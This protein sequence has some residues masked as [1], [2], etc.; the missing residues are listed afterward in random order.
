M[1]HSSKRNPCPVCGRNT[2]DKCRWN[3]STILCYCGSVF[4]PPQDISIGQFLQ[5][6]ENR[7]KL[8]SYYSGF[9]NAS[10]LFAKVNESE[11]LSPLQRYRKK[12][13]ARVV[14]KQN[15]VEY[16]KSFI[17]IRKLMHK[18]F[19]VKDPQLL[20][21]H[22]IEE[23]KKLFAVAIKEC[24]SLLQFIAE[25]KSRITLK[26]SQVFALNYWGKMLDY[27]LK[28]I[29]LFER[30]YLG[31]SKCPDDQLRDRPGLEPSNKNKKL[32]WF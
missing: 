23:A 26:K 20:K 17:D 22:E 32:D 31:V 14:A 13:E 27:G 1:Q 7:W 4:H 28:D 12:A 30:V 21:L 18:C 8:I 5:I 16:K 11:L 25:N 9:S 19:A 29:L 3:S 2:D 24:S 6:N 10:Y 15:I